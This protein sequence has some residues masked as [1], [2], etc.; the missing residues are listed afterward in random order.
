[1]GAAAILPLALSLF[2]ACFPEGPPNTDNEPI[3]VAPCHVS[4]CSKEICSERE[5][6]PSTCEFRPQYA[7]YQNA[8]CEPQANGACNWTLTAELNNCL[9]NAGNP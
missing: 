3:V 7:C 5:N 1:M 6:V 9:V 2:L 4:G 8:R